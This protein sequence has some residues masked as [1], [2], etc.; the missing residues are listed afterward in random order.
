MQSQNF[1]LC[2]AVVLIQGRHEFRKEYKENGVHR[3]VSAAT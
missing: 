1:D 3:T 2:L